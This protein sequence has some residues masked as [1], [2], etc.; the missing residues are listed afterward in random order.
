MKKSRV[1]LIKCDTYDDRQ[2]YEAVEAGINLLGG[3]SNF[4]K[5]D[6]R[7]LIKPNVLIGTNP[8]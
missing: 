5:P 2:V 8:Q 6:E 7:I 1:A 4:I 3:I